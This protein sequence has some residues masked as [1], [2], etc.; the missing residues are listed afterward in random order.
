MENG[1]FRR[2]IKATYQ[3]RVGER[4]DGRTELHSLALFMRPISFS[5]LMA[6][7]MSPLMRSFPD[8]NAIVGFSFPKTQ[9]RRV[10]YITTQRPGRC[11]PRRSSPENIL[12][13][14]LESIF[15]MTSALTEGS[16]G[17]TLPAPLFRSRNQ[18]PACSPDGH[19]DSHGTNTATNRDLHR[20]TNSCRSQREIHLDSQW[21]SRF[22]DS[23]QLCEGSFQIFRCHDLCWTPRSPYETCEDL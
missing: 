4:R 2:I 13:K 11:R 3:V 18:I 20:S 23:D 10:V 1:H 16:P 5:S 21:V 8:M 17:P 14:S 22:L 9:S 12:L 19:K 7:V 15:M 6:M